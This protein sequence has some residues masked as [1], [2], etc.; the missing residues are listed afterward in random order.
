MD[1]ILKSHVLARAIIRLSS[2]GKE[3]GAWKRERGGELLRDRE[4]KATYVR[5]LSTA[6]YISTQVKTPIFVQ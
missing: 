4:G 1:E 5:P 6:G 3:A 2:G